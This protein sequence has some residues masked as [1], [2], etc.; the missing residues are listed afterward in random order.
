M[1]EALHSDNERE[2]AD[3]VRWRDAD[4]DSV[5]AL[6]AGYGIEIVDVP[7][8]EEIPGSY[9]GDDEAGLIA[10]RLYARPDTPLH[11]ILHE[12]C[13]FI[14][15]DDERR[16]GLHT[17]AGGDYDEENAVCY[18][19]IVLA[20]RV[21]GYGSERCMLDMDRWGYTFRLGS[22]RAWFER[23]AEDAVEGLRAR[24]IEV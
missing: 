4:R 12:S 22:A 1:N 6:L 5:A 15:M 13:H 19:Q 21:R 10:D 18:L 20:D 2:T 9:W 3:V 16:A 8:G 23:D 24:G 14:C 7:A 11:S 17:D